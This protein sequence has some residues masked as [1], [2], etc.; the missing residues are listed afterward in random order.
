[1]QQ[2]TST[3]PPPTIEDQYNEFRQQVLIQPP[4]PH[5][6]QL[7]HQPTSYHGPD[8]EEDL[9]MDALL[10]NVSP[11]RGGSSFQMS[12]GKNSTQPTQATPRKSAH[13]S[14][15]TPPTLQYRNPRLEDAS[16]SQTTK[17]RKAED[18]MATSTPKVA[19]KH[20][21][22]SSNTRSKRVPTLGIDMLSQMWLGFPMQEALLTQLGKHTLQ[23][24]RSDEE[25][26]AIGTPPTEIHEF[27]SL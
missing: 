21:T 8:E 16:E 18:Y 14:E 13:I 7:S 11:E 22:P 10:E 12:L 23:E 6:A 20:T 19:S 25:F 24:S 3:T 17:R 1:M 27:R 5:A 9:D 15:S 2:H 26:R 4:L